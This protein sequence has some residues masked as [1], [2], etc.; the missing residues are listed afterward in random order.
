MDHH[1]ADAGQKTRPG[2]LTCISIVSLCAGSAHFKPW[3]A[4]WPT[5]RSALRPTSVFSDAVCGC[6]LWVSTNLH[7]SPLSL[8]WVS[9]D[10][11][12]FSGCP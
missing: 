10:S 9:T 11:T 4:S 7:K 2:A 6:R 3:L 1:F 12:D 5:T 8:S